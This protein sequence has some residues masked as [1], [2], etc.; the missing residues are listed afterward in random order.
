MNMKAN[1]LLRVGLIGVLSL[2]VAGC[3][4]KL[5]SLAHQD[6]VTGSLV[7]GR[8]LTVLTG[9]RTRRYGPQ[10]RFLELEDQDSSKRFHVEIESP[11]QRFAISLPPGKY[12][13]TRVQISE[14][15]FMSMADLSMAFSVDAGA[16]TYVGT[17]RFE[18]DSPRYGR[19]VAVTV[20]VDQAESARVRDFLAEQY[21]KLNGRS[22]IET[23][24]QPTMTNVRL[25]EVMPYPRY[26]TYFRRKW[27]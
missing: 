7:V 1:R 6:Q 23:L 14:G 16:V 12:Q 19:M 2:S 3:M 4:T 18:V 15:P 25:Y 9:E 17:W 10:I 5:P 8:I 22:M 13:L 26:P 21:P 24:P 27:W 20:V 11:D